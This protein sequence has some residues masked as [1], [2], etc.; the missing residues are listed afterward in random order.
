MKFARSVQA[1]VDEPAS[2][3]GL[4]LEQSSRCYA[5]CWNSARPQLMPT[6]VPE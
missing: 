5:R 4:T 2:G 1:P 6:T 3:D